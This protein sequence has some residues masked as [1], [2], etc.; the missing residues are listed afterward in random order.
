MDILAEWLRGQ[1]EDLLSGGSNPTAVTLFLA[2]FGGLGG[3]APTHPQAR[4]PPP[5]SYRHRR[6]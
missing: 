1:I 5:C 6:A 4:P 2:A 3:V